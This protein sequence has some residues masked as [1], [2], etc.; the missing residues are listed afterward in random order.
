ML[1]HNI[2]RA[3]RQQNWAVVLIELLVVIVGLVLAFQVDRW[4]EGR[5]DRAQEREYIARLIAE[6]EEDVVL[7]THGVELAQVR[8]D[9][10]DLLL[11]VM[12]DRSVADEHP[13]L[14][15]ASVA[16]AAFTFSPSLTNHTF[17]DLR[18]TGSMSLIRGDDVRKGLYDYYGFHAAQQQF[19]QLNLN[20]EMRYFVLA[21]DVLDAEQYQ[22]VQDQWFVVLKQNLDEVRAARPDM[23]AFPGA[24]QRFLDNTDLQ[25][26]VPRMRG[27]Q[28]EQL[29]MHGHQLDKAEALLALLQDYAATL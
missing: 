25:A 18:S 19:I 29:L 16:Q 4:W 9:M 10:G 26:W 5:A 15:L 1:I 17:E 3:L 23:A 6:V 8:Q 28:R 24:V 12:E 7:I 13:G 22:W 27:V 2:A 20:I 14:F 11:A 21:A